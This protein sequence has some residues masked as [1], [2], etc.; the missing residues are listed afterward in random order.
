[1]KKLIKKIL[2][3]SDFDWAEDTNV[4]DGDK[5]RTLILKDGLTEIYHEVVNGSLNLYG[6]KIQSLGNLES[7]GDDLYLVGSKIKSLGNLES[8]GGGL[9]LRITEIKSLGNLE[10]VGGVLHL[11]GTP[12]SKNYSEEE[13]MEMV[14]V[15]D[16]IYI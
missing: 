14:S 12:L 1:M 9:D 10:T 7:V 8:V 6:S 16:E 3:E 11:E 15:G 4:I 2:R 5:L 13:I